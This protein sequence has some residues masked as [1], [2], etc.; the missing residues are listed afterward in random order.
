[1]IEG[2]RRAW[3]IARAAWIQDRLRPKMARQRD[4]IDFLPAAVEIQERPASP[5]GRVLA[6]LISALMLAALA[7][8]WFGKIDTVAVAPGRIIPG[9]KVK[10]IQPLE[11][12]VVRAIHVR[13]GQAVRRDEVLIEIDPAEEAAD[14]TRLEQDLMALRL[15]VAWLSAMSKQP[16]DPLSVFVPPAEVEE[17]ALSV[18]RDLMSAEAAEY[19]EVLA[20]IDAE[21]RQRQAE[22]ETISVRIAGLRQTVPLIRQRVDAYRRLVSKEYA[23][24]LKFTE[25]EEELISREHA[26]AVEQRKIAE[27]REAIAVLER[28]RARHIASVAGRVRRDLSQA[29]RM[30]ARLEQEFA[31]AGERLRARNLRSP[32]DGI[33]QQLAVHTLGGV[34]SPAQRLMAVVPA[35]TALEVEAML[36]NRDVGFV[37]TGQSAEIKVESFPFTR[38]GLIDGEV[39]QVSADAVADE[40][41]GP[42]FPM[43]VSMKR[44]RILVGDRWV[45]LAPGMSVAVEVKTGKRRAID[46]FLSPFLRYQAEALR[47]R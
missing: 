31:K 28:R 10:V 14:R 39:M 1:M 11:M 19:R 35:D 27:L 7:W 6:L 21:K 9:E 8:G 13:D 45:A 37:Q 18:A 17:A 5:A 15:D 32:V 40:R 46:F 30:A 36:L 20:G 33:V 22:R 4:E 47:E 23:S 43:R 3:S 24:R 42:V 25:M 12:G 34:V 29:M 38:Y 44:D 16:S 26:L 41:L 2:L